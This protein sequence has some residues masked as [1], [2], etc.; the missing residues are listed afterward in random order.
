L[1]WITDSLHLTVT[2]MAT[3]IPPLPLAPAPWSCKGEVYWIFLS[4]S[5]TVEPGA[6]APLEASVSPIATNEVGH[7]TGKGMGACVMIVRYSETPVGPY[8]EL[9]YTPGAFTTPPIPGGDGK[10]HLRLTRIYV[11]ESNPETIYNGRI[12]W[13]VPKHPA[14]FEFKEISNSETRIS[15]FPPGGSEAEPADAPFFSTIISKAGSFLPSIP[16]SSSVIPVD[17]KLVLPPLPASPSN[18]ALAGTDSWR[19]FRS[20]LK[21]K[22]R[23]IWVKP[24]DTKD[25]DGKA[26]FADGVG[27]PKIQPWSL[28]IYWTKGTQIDV[29]VGELYSDVNKKTV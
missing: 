4:P 15:V 29:P 2:V 27:F 3:I 23:F 1:N 26:Q 8:D 10:P 11:S 25:D 12:N 6:Y 21:G 16:L 5:K 9:M 20:S 28:G 24:G 7:P 13:N 22:T 14:R 17:V 19:S 18:P